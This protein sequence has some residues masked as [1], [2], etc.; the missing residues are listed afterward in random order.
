MH[1]RPKINWS[2]IPQVEFLTGEAYVAYRDPAG[3]YHD[4]LFR[5]FH[6]R[7][8]HETDGYYYPFVAVTESRD[9]INWTQSRILPPRTTD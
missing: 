1:Q 4:E 3:H 9:L 2:D 5:V 6:T 8:L 7:V